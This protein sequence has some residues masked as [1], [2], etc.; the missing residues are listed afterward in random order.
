[1]IK[2]FTVYE[3][4]WIRDCVLSDHNPWSD[5]WSHNIIGFYLQ[6][7]GFD[8][9]DDR[10]NYRTLQ[11]W[12]MNNRSRAERPEVSWLLSDV[13][14]PDY[15]QT[16]LLIERIYLDYEAVKRLLQDVFLTAGIELVFEQRKP[17]E[18]AP[19]PPAESYHYIIIDE[20]GQDYTD[21]VRA[22]R[23]RF[24]SAHPVVISTPYTATI[25]ATWFLEPNEEDPFLDE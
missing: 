15:F 20:G 4:R 6:A 21:Y 10:R 1:V 3:D 13:L 2:Q 19:E 12:L 7:L 23:E 16:I 18:V 17:Q 9:E 24:A 25:E 5:V 11:S 14:V 8:L 22:I